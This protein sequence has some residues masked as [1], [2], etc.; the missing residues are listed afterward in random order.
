[1]PKAGLSG[2]P[3]ETSRVPAAPFRHGETQPPPSS[4]FVQAEHGEAS[5]EYSA[6]FELVK[7]KLEKLI[8]PER[9]SLRIYNLGNHYSGK[10]QHIGAKPSYDAEDV[11]IV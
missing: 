4:V 11:L 5:R 10:I 7:H 8:D 6:K 3:L 2:P 1:M 9:D